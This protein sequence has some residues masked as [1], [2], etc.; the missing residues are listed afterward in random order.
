[1]SSKQGP[2]EVKMRTPANAVES[3]HHRTQTTTA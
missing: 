1:M 3:R 2:H